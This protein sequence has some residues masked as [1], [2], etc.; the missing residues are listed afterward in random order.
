MSLGGARGA[1]AK[2]R[3][4]AMSRTGR[5]IGGD[6][7]RGRALLAGA[8]LASLV[9]GTS[10]ATAAK[11]DIAI[12]GPNQ[13]FYVDAAHQNSF[14]PLPKNGQWLLEG[15]ENGQTID[16]RISILGTQSLYGGQV[17]TRI[18]EEREWAD[19]NG[20]RKPQTSEL[21]EVSLNYFAETADHTVCYFGELVNGDPRPEAG[22]WRADDLGNA[23]GIFMPAVPKTGMS[24]F[25]ES[26][27]DVAEDQATIIGVG[28]VEVLGQARR[29]VIRVHETNR[30]DQDR[31]YKQYAPGIGLVSDDTLNLVSVK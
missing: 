8:V 31:G 28:T 21:I 25:Q 16:L 6:R 26:A 10:P 20:D 1:P 13:P 2:G 17:T 24:F 12:C 5:W 9:L 19:L 7:R 3:I 30:L 14:F 27:P 18:V 23:P 11:L 29:D 4:E 15:P 22:S